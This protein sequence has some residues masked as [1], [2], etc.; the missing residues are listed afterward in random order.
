MLPLCCQVWSR[1][2]R[3]VMEKM[4]RALKKCIGPLKH[5]KKKDESCKNVNGLCEKM[6]GNECTACEWLVLMCFSLNG[7]VKRNLFT[8]NCGQNLFVKNLFSNGDQSVKGSRPLGDSPHSPILFM[9]C[10]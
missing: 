7:V 4:R 3:A 6:T 10:P 2:K 8:E 1:F 9:C 5:T